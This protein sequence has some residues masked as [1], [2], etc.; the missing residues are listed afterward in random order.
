MQM[1][2]NAQWFNP[3]CVNRLEGETHTSTIQTVGEYI[4]ED[5][6]LYDAFK[7]QL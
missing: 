3:E 5:K 6:Y 2:R 1:L 4:A 7:R